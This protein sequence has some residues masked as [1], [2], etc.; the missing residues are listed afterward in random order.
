[1]ATPAQPPDDRARELRSFVALAVATYL[2]AAAL[3][4]LFAAAAAP[5]SG[6]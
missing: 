2:A 4:F 6:F 1:M 5:P 3:F